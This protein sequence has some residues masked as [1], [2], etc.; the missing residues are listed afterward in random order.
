MANEDGGKKDSGSLLSA[1]VTAAPAVGG[2]GYAFRNV[3]KGPRMAPRAG[4]F[5]TAARRA[6]ATVPQSSVGDILSRLAGARDPLS[7]IGPQIPIDQFLNTSEGGEAA[8]LAWDQAVQSLGPIPS[9]LLGFPKDMEKVPANHVYSTIH[10]ALTQ[11]KSTYVKKVAIRFRQNVQSFVRHQRITGTLPNL[12]HAEEFQLPAALRNAELPP[13][14]QGQFNR[15]KSTLKG[16]VVNADYYTRPGWQERGLGMYQLQFMHQGGNLRLNVPIASGGVLAEGLSQSSLKVAREWQ[17][18]DPRTGGV[19]GPRLK[20]HE[21]LM[22]DFE[23][24]IL[25]KLQAGQFK[26]MYEAQRVVDEMYEKNIRTLENLTNLPGH[27]RHRGLSRY[28]ANKAHEVAFVEYSGHRTPRRGESFSSVYSNV[29]TAQH[30]AIMAA[31][32]VTPSAGPDQLAS[33]ILSTL[34]P[35]QWTSTPEAMDFV[36]RPMQVNREW[37]PTPQA[38]Q[39]M[40]KTP[41]AILETQGWRKDMGVYAGPHRETLFIDPDW[42]N[43]AGIFENAELM[44]KFGLGPG[45]SGLINDASNRRMSSA[46][47][48]SSVRLKSARQDLESLIAS[49]KLTPGETLGMTLQGHPLTYESGMKLTGLKRFN[50]LG[51]GNFD[52]LFFEEYVHAGQSR[53]IF[54]PHGIKGI[55]SFWNEGKTW[56]FEKAVSSRVKNSRLITGYRA[57]ASMEGL[58]KQPSAH[59]HQMMSA[60]LEVLMNRKTRKSGKLSSFMRNPSVF[61]SRLS[62]KATTNNVYSHDAMV[63]SLMSFG[64]NEARLDPAEFGTVFGTVP[65]VLGKGRAQELVGNNA[66]FD[67]MN[68]GFARGVS[69]AI[70]A[71][72]VNP[73]L[74]GAGGRASVEP[75]LLQMLENGPLGALGQDLSA[76]L[77]YRLRTSNPDAF[78][79]HSALTQTLASLAGQDKAGSSIFNAKNYSRSSFQE[80]VEQGGGHIRAPGMPDVY[81]PGAHRVPQMGAFTTG[82]GESTFSLSNPFHAFAREAKDATTSEERNAIMNRLIGE[83]GMQQAPGGAGAGAF[84]RQG[85][86]AGTRF[87]TAVSEANGQRTNSMWTVGLPEAHAERMFE[88]MSSIY[89]PEKVAAMRQRFRSGDEIQGMIWR[90]PITSPFSQVPVNMKILRGVDEAK[91]TIP[92]FQAKVRLAGEEKASLRMLSPGV[93]MGQ[94]FDADAVAA[95]LVNPDLQHKI[96]KNFTYAENN[97]THSYI[98]HMVRAQLIS[99]KSVGGGADVGMDNFRK[100]VAASRNLGTP[101]EWVGRLSNQFSE[102]RMAAGQYLEGNKAAD[103]GWLLNWLEEVPTSGKHL[104]VDI[105]SF[106]STVGEGFKSRD[107]NM[108]LGALNSIF[109]NTSQ[110]TKDLLTKNVGIEEGLG[111]IRRITGQANLPSFLRGVNLESTLDS[112]FTALR[113]SDANEATNIFRLAAG[114]RQLSSSNL[115]N[116]LLQSG[117]LLKQG[118]KGMM[119]GVSTAAIAAKNFVMRAG[120]TAIAHKKALA[121]GFAGS[122]ALATIMSTPQDTLGPSA[123][124]RTNIKN[125]SKAVNRMELP[126]PSDATPQSTG[127]PSVPVMMQPSVSIAP[128]SDSVRMSIRARSRGRVNASILGGN[129]GSLSGRNASVNV[130]VRDRTSSM[131]PHVLANK[132]F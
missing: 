110:V 105:N 50:T 78:E 31:T 11:N 67:A 43:K 131:S 93:G 94:D 53:K 102:M 130:N 89:D 44:Q 61:M 38:V 62:S 68:S 86:L 6:P 54:S 125:A 57:I 23:E 70:F 113:S 7:T 111:D 14:L 45:E 49:G 26:N 35:R 1:A 58:K 84:L 126:P 97:A 127:R 96:A 103:V 8:R 41:W 48:A 20:A 27:L 79:A 22:K 116:Y 72:N 65:Y 71:G 17:V 25:P 83:V 122:L 101:Q 98:E 92:W 4:A 85:N 109:E 55:E 124:P 115:K 123:P 30:S 52:T 87:F 60:M 59:N 74:M 104:K 95:M 82:A 29:K 118:P 36:R 99:A 64:L 28:G 129:V 32:G 121:W 46:Y 3:F 69:Q 75:R 9:N 80:W 24:S 56:E 39:E 66:Y 81:V 37:I 15:I 76:D 47:R 33:G 2:L 12:I 100:M 106:L 88:E 91:M 5:S 120:E 77:M 108:T 19:V 117:D 107:K 132:L 10:R 112:A 51:S 13:E 21:F 73:E 114:R 16:W 42:Q 128:G 119:A 90:H 34:D 63:Q 18:W 40:M